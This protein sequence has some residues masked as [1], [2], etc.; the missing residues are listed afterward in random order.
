MFEELI[1][2]LKKAKHYIFMEF[3]IVSRGYMWDTILEVLK[4]RVNDGVEVRFMYDD[5]GCVDLLL[6]KYYKELERFGIM[7]MAL[8]RSNHLFQRHGITEIIEK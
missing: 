3:F 8:I 7:A 4:D 6:Y 1:E 2:D 5:V